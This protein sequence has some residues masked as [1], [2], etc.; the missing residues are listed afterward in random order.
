MQIS[1][2]QMHNVLKGV[3]KLTPELADHLL[4]CFDMTVLDLVDLSD[5]NLHVLQRQ[6]IAS[7][8]EAQSS[9]I[10]EHIGIQHLPAARSLPR[11]RQKSQQATSQSGLTRT[12]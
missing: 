5:L 1:Q 9:A 6:K 2:P 11:K 12:A 3:R 4:Q 8:R 7:L 10:A